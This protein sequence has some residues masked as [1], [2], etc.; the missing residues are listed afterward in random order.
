MITKNYIRFSIICLVIFS[1]VSV[2]ATATSY[3]VPHDSDDSEVIYQL[4]QH[5]TS[6]GVE[7]LSGQLQDLQDDMFFY[8]VN[9]YNRDKSLR[10]ELRKQFKDGAWHV[11]GKKR[12]RDHCWG[13]DAAYA[14]VGADH[15][16]FRFFK[17]CDRS[18]QHNRFDARF[19]HNFLFYNKFYHHRRPVWWQHNDFKKCWKSSN[20]QEYLDCRK[21]HLPSYNPHWPRADL[22]HT[23][24]TDYGRN[25]YVS[26]SNKCGKVIQRQGPRQGNLESN[27][28][29]ARQG[30][31]QD[32]AAERL[33][34]FQGANTWCKARSWWMAGQAS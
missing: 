3:V 32:Q 30:T 34:R 15:E 11:K 31:L 1:L 5:R 17:N 25:A 21:A 24:V 23:G 14:K 8:Q 22:K 7:A 19:E 12:Y 20:Y 16:F 26:W 6:Q 28:D 13:Y 4:Q 27:A 9:E 18:P 33:K 10:D 2:F 29:R